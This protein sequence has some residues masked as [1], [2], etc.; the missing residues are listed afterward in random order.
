MKRRRFFRSVFSV[1]AQSRVANIILFQ[2]IRVY[3]VGS[4]WSYFQIGCSFNCITANLRVLRITVKGI[5]HDPINTRNIRQSHKFCSVLS[6]TLNLSA[7]ST[8]EH[9]A[10]LI[11]GVQ[12]N[13][14]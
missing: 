2:G 13:Q 4:N 10:F 7:V 1:G 5:A 3:N 8:K 14:D 6:V 9:S 11:S 12:I